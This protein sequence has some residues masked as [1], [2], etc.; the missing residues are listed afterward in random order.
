MIEAPWMG[1]AA[2]ALL[3]AVACGGQQREAAAP[4][5]RA[6]AKAVESTAASVGAESGTRDVGSTTRVPAE[7]PLAALVG[8]EWRW[9]KFADPV[10]GSLDVD[11]PEDY[12]L[13]LREDGT[14][15]VRSDCNTGSGVYSID[16]S[17]LTVRI[18]KITL[19]TCGENSLTT[20]FVDNL[21]SSA[22]Y[23]MEDGN[24]FVDLRYDS[25]TMKFSPGR[26]LE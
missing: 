9:S 8:H 11:N 20:E 14:A 7:V 10:A 16:G 6:Q 23:F 26:R 25:G 2:L 13:T 12:S 1:G 21:N 24:L 18:T 17:E 15:R 3:A 5:Q 22:S 19:D 4:E